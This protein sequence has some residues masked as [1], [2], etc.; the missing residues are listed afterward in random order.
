MP[1]AVDKAC[2]CLKNTVVSKPSRRAA[3]SSLRFRDSYRIFFA[4]YQG[5]LYNSLCS[6]DVGV[7]GLASHWIKS[8]D[9]SLPMKLVPRSRGSSLVQAPFD[10]ISDIL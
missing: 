6:D 5:N 7:L 2:Q 9:K 4:Y 8:T 10:V 1:P 3:V